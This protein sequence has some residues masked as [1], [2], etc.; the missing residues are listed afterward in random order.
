MRRERPARAVDD[1]PGR[2]AGRVAARDA[3]ERRDRRRRCGWRTGRRRRRSRCSAADRTCSCR[4]AAC[5]AWSMRPRGGEIRRARRRARARGRGG[6]DQ[7]AGPLDDQSR[8]R[9]PR[10]VGRHARHR[11]RRDLR[12]RALRR[13]PDRRSA[14]VEVRLVDPRRRDARCAACGDGVRLRSQPAAADAA[15]C[16]SRRCSAWRR[17]TR[18]RCGRR[19]ASRWRFAS[20]RSRSTRRAPGCI[21][22]NP[23]PGR[24]RVPEGIPWSAGAL[25][26]RAG[27]KGAGGRRR[28]R[29]AGARQLHRQRG[30]RHGARHPDAHRSLP[31]PTCASSSAS[32]CA[33]RSSTLA[34]S[35]DD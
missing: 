9:R 11:R 8:M 28:A 3:D 6:D 24:D 34:T 25:V 27:L 31:R 32:S 1:V 10:G 33:K 16:C 5:A 19:R 29:V 23:D 18:R 2:R 35:T 12:Q 30:R 21:F 26:D 20:G 14:S 4:I 13:A 17:A 7:R 15:R 22:Q